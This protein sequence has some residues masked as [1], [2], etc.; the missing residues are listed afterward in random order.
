MILDFADPDVA[1]DHSADVCVVGAGVAGIAVAQQLLGTGRSVLLLESGGLEAD[2]TVSRLTRGEMAGLPLRI[3][4]GR[5]RVFGGT[6]TVWP[7]QCIRLDPSDFEVRDWVPHS[8]WP[9]TADALEPWYERAEAWLGIP[10]RDSDERAWRRFGLTPPELDPQQVRHKS[11]VYSPHPDV[12]ALHR[13]AFAEAG[14]L[15]VLLHATAVGLRLGGDGSAPESLEIRSGDG[16]V[17][18][19]TAG[20]FVLAGGGIENARLLLLSGIGRE[21]DVVGRFLQDHPTVWADVETDRPEALQEFYGW[22][23]RGR[24]RYVPRIRL[25]RQVQRRHRVLNAIATFVY[26]RRETR[27]VTAAKALSR[28]VQQRR[29]L[30]DV[31]PSDVRGLAGEL[32]GVARAAFRRFV[33]G[34]PSAEPLARTQVQ[35]LLEQAPHPDSRLT[36]SDELDDLG[37]PRVRVDWRL[38]ELERRTARTAV[39][40]LDAELRRL[41]LGRVVGTEWLEGDDWAA[42]LEDAFHNI[43]TTRMSADPATGVVDP[44]CR[45][46]GVP[47]LFVVG[48]S[49][50][51]TS[52]YANPTLTIVAL[53]LRLADH[54]ASKAPGA[55][56]W[57]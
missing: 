47:G 5:A 52:G 28:A 13:A 39:D 34:R 2:E 25:D 17:G 6:G 51:P 10:A 48:S 12:G 49:V 32:D 40:V 42:R 23:G 35:I 54:L 56:A 55:A 33:R 14:D 20:T 45:V 36:L 43:G 26:Q 53:A 41:G 18:R 44:D 30:T 27:G 57:T 21:H 16:R 3:E 9:L 38:S 37:T 11:A 50:F 7:G 24:V 15:R 46:H 8:G 19:V 31:R 29:W 4:Q 1:P 22:L